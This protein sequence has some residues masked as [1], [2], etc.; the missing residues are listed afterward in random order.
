MVFYMK[1]LETLQPLV[2]FVL[3]RPK[4][5]ILTRSLVRE[6]LKSLIGLLIC[7]V[8]NKMLLITQD[9]KTLRVYRQK[10]EKLFYNTNVLSNTRNSQNIFDV[11]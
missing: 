8:P 2:L 10:K 4:Y 3:L 7:E 9:D 11:M 1:T 5:K 6:R